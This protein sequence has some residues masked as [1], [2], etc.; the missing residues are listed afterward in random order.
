MLESGWHALIYCHWEVYMLPLHTLHSPQLAQMPPLPDW[1]GISW[2]YH[3]DDL[4]FDPVWL[5]L[6]LSYGEYCARH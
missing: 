1:I 6:L 2:L 4:S 5:G 3:S